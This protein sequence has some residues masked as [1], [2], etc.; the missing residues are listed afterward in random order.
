MMIVTTITVNVIVIIKVQISC[1]MLPACSTLLICFIV[2]FSLLLAYFCHW[3]TA[4]YHKFGNG[5]LA[6]LLFMLLFGC[7]IDLLLCVK[8]CR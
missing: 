8:I 6:E 4:N 5:L 7:F 1:F 2:N 3:W